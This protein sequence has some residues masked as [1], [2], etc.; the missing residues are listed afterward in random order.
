L[1]L[2]GLCKLNGLSRLS[3]VRLKGDL[4]RDELRLRVQWIG[5]LVRTLRVHL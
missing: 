4:L 5:G 3:G 1:G 2:C